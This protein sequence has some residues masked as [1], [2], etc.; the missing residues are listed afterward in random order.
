MGKSVVSLSLDEW[1]NAALI[2]VVRDCS[3]EPLVHTQSRSKFRGVI[4]STPISPHHY[5]T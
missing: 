2:V 3:I 1:I 4:Q 5:R